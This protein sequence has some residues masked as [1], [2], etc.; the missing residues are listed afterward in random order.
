[1]YKFGITNNLVNVAKA[2][3]DNNAKVQI[4]FE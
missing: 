2:H 1:M 3:F 4:I